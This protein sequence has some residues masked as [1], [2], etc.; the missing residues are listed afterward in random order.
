MLHKSKLG[1]WQTNQTGS[2]PLSQGSSANLIYDPQK[3]QISQS[4]GLISSITDMVSGTI[5]ATASGAQRP[6]LVQSPIDGRNVIRF[7]GS[8]ELNTAST[9]IDPRNFTMVFVTDLSNFAGGSGNGQGVL[10]GLGGGATRSIF[11]NNASVAAFDVSTLIGYGGTYNT[12]TFNIITIIGNATN[13]IARCNGVEL[14]NSPAFSATPNFTNVRLGRA[15][16]LVQSLI[17]CDI[18]Y[19]EIYNTALD[20]TARAANENRIRAL[21]PVKTLSTDIK[22]FYFLG[23][24]LTEG[25]GNTA[26]DKRWTE[27]SM[28]GSNLNVSAR[29][30]FLV[31]GYAGATTVQLTGAINPILTRYMGNGSNSYVF[32]WELSN[33]INISQNGTTAYSNLTTLCQNIKNDAPNT[34]IIVMTMLP[35]GA[36]AAV[37]TAR[38]VANNLVMAGTSVVGGIS[39]FYTKGSDNI[40]FVFDV[41]GI[42]T[43]GTPGSQSNTTYYQADQVHLTDT[44]YALIGSNGKDI[45]N[46]FV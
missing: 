41:S 17:G 43:I 26:R 44:G 31:R 37:E 9:N 8:M 34:K 2:Q 39:N 40:D 25:R 22:R 24:S 6:M 33:D 29:E 11:Y 28:Y 23:N 3:S 16:S 5:Q 45:I 21:V 1:F 12:G 32:V 36:V 15:E 30:N 42:G 18:S 46:Y 35:R 19:F 20:A 13:V 10:A 14:F 27:L 7:N 38:I 4:G